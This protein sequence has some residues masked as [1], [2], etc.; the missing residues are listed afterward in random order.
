MKAPR[1]MEEGI[2]RETTEDW[3]RT[4]LIAEFWALMII[5]TA[6]CAIGLHELMFL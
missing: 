4:V 1:F 2:L 5:G 3:Q 6:L